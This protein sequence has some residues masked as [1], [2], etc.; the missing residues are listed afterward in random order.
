MRPISKKRK[1]VEQQERLHLA[2]RNFKRRFHT[3][4]IPWLRRIMRFLIRLFFVQAIGKKN[5]ENLKLEKIQFSFPN[6]P[7]AFDNTRILLITDLHL[8]NTKDSEERLMKIVKNI[9]FDYCF[10]G[11]D[12]TNRWQENETAHISLTKITKELLKKSRVFGVLGNND[13]YQIARTL[14][15][16]GA[17]MLINE[18]LLIERNNDKIYLAG[19]DDCCEYYALADTKLANQNAE[20]NSFKIMLAHAPDKYREAENQGYDLYLTGHTHGGQICLPFG[21]AVI[22][23]TTVPRTMVKGKWNYHAMQGYTSRGAGTTN[24]KARY[25]C[26]P[27]I[28]LITLRKTTAN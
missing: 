9:D 25:F 18:G 4:N 12:Y 2:K 26:P 11:G 10:L 14:A 19:I 21:I 3:E 7:E 8:D 16:A 24:I 28:T 13:K 20:K 17:E 27:E 1:L 23:G 5:A 6:L 15:R 22:T